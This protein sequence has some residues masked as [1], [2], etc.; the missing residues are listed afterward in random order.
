[1]RRLEDTRFMAELNTLTTA[2]ERVST[3]QAIDAFAAARIEQWYL[4]KLRREFMPYAKG[5]LLD[6]V[7]LYARCLQ[8]ADRFDVVLAPC[9]GAFGAGKVQWVASIDP[10]VIYGPV[11]ELEPHEQ[12]RFIAKLLLAAHEAL[13][14]ARRR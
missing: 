11:I 7:V 12:W 9:A 13:Y 8:L 10:A 2:M 3:K 1:M 6:C 4:E 14:Q 5:E